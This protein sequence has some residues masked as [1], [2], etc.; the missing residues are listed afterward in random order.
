MLTVE[1]AGLR[2]RKDKC[3]LALPEA[4]F[5]GHKISAADVHSKLEKVQAITNAPEPIDKTS[6]QPFW[7]C[8]PSMTE[9]CKVTQSCCRLSKHT[10][11]KWGE[12]HRTPFQ[13]LKRLI[14]AATVMTY[15]FERK[16]LKLSCNASH[17]GVGA[18]LA[19]LD[20]YGREAVIAFASRTLGLAE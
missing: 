10:E 8:W 2:L 14:K 4:V 15:Y 1:S 11:L 19:Q 6:L 13:D 12:K 20:F 17:D 16:P 5:L 18:V 7:G 9:F 3:R